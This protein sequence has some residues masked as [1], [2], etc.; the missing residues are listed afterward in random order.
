MGKELFNLRTE[1]CVLYF[2]SSAANEVVCEEL[3][4]NSGTVGESQRRPREIRAAV[5]LPEIQVLIVRF[6]TRDLRILF[7]KLEKSLN[8]S[9]LDGICQTFIGPK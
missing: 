1:H 5:S 8:C 4:R 7:Y 2:K 6:V 9:Q 3:Q